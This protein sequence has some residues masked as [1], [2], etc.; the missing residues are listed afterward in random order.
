MTFSIPQDQLEREM[1]SADVMLNLY[2]MDEDSPV[3]KA[4][5][6]VLESLNG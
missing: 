5:K 6:E 1:E 3:Q 4:K 2:L